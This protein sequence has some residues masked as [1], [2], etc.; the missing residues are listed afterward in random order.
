[1]GSDLRLWG[2]NRPGTGACVQ[3]PHVLVVDAEWEPV[4]AQQRQVSC[5]GPGLRAPGVQLEHEPPSWVEELIM[6]HPK[7]QRGR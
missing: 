2:D 5:R 6:S 1:M 3:G 7:S 4:S